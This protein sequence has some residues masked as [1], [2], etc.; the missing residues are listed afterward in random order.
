MPPQGES[1]GICI[2]DG[3]ALS[4][5][6]IH[7]Q[8][9]PLRSIFEAYEAFRRPQTDAA[10]KEANWR[11]ETAKDKGWWVYQLIVRSTSWFLWWTAKKRE[12]E[13]CGDVSGMHFEIA[14]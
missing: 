2:E 12:E 11:W 7:H 8:T 5:A 3:I 14:G 4:R 10:V 13:F 1:T 6:M 9:K